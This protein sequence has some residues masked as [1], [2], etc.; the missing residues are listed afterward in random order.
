MYGLLTTA[1]LRSLTLWVH[2]L[3]SPHK[4]PHVCSILSSSL[5]PLTLWVLSS[6][7]Q[8]LASCVSLYLPPGSPHVCSILNASLRSLTSWVVSFSLHSLTLWA[9]SFCSTH[10]SPHVCSVLSSSLRSLT[11]WV[12]LPAYNYPLQTKAGKS[13]HFTQAQNTIFLTHTSYTLLTSPLRYPIIL[14][15]QSGL[16]PNHPDRSTY[17]VKQPSQQLVIPSHLGSCDLQTQAGKSQHFTPSHTYLSTFSTSPPRYSSCS[18]TA[19]P[20]TDLPA[21]NTY[22]VKQPSQQPVISPYWSSCDL[23]TQTGKSRHFTQ[24]HNTI[25]LTH[26]SHTL[27]TSPSRY[28]IILLIQPGLAPTYPDR[29]TYSVRQLSQQLVI[30]SHLGSCDLQHRQVSPNTSPKLETLSF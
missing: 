23:Q 17:G 21:R 27:L 14:L 9:H 10:K 5:R 24:A 8:S 18:F 29:S 6:R 25:V 30:P 26:T 28:P 12:Y 19:R 22:R 11:L 15:T 3:C 20:H 13:R 7:L 1:S 16:A 2:S 4:S